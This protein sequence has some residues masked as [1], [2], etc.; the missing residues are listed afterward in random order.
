MMSLAIAGLAAGGAAWYL[1]G[2]EK[3]RNLCHSLSDS[4]RD[5]S[6]TVKDKVSSRWNEMANRAEDVADNMNRKADRM[7]NRAE[8][9]MDNM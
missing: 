7:A 2:T 9:A 4:A 6:N 3:G 1:L 8:N 5:L